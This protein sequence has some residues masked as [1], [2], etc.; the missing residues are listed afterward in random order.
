MQCL[1]DSDVVS[2]FIRGRDPIV[3]RRALAYLNRYSQAGISL[4]TRYEVRRGYLAKRATRLLALLEMF[5]Q[6]NIVLDID[7]PIVDRASEIWANLSRAGQSIGDSDPII[8]ATALHHG[9]GIA[10]RNVTHFN[11]IPGLTV[12][13]WS[14]P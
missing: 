8:A 13:D 9:L 4:F 6:H 3:R 14:L 11:R 7:N 2:Q 10:T 1:W 12:E 5:C